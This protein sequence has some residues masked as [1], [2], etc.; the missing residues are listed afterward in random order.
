MLFALVE[1]QVLPTDVVEEISRA[2]QR[3]KLDDYAHI[4]EVNKDV[5]IPSKTVTGTKNQ[6]IIDFFPFDPYLLR[7]SKPFIESLYQKWEIP[8]HQPNAPSDEEQTNSNSFSYDESFV[9]SYGSLSKS[10]RN[11]M[12]LSTS[13]SEDVSVRDDQL[14]HSPED[15]ESRYMQEEEDEN[16]GGSDEDDGI[17]E[18]EE[19]NKTFCWADYAVNFA[20]SEHNSRSPIK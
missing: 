13:F 2:F 11:T 12:V 3:Y 18:D 14:A 16:A 9:S 8:K 10:N 6:L 7:N 20:G 19:E 17:G 5:F 1:Q 15:D 4:L